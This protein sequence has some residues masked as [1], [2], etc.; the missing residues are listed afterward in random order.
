MRLLMKI[1]TMRDATTLKIAP[2]LKMVCEYLISL[3]YVC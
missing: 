1:V 2:R 3:M